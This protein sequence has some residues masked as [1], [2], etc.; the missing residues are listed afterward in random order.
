MDSSNLFLFL[1]GLTIYFWCR[2]YCRADYDADE[3]VRGEYAAIVELVIK[4]F[5]GQVLYL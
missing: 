5:V 1:I 4:G 2:Y 3:D